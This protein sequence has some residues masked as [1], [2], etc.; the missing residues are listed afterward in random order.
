MYSATHVWECAISV[1]CSQEK[2]FMGKG[3]YYGQLVTYCVDHCVISRMLLELV[4]ANFWYLYA[5]GKFRHLTQKFSSVKV[6]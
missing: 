5:G 3:V 4:L 6:A 2:K 1:M